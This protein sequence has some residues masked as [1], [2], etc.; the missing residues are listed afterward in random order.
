MTR[1]LSVMK[2]SV[3]ILLGIVLVLGL[4]AFQHFMGVVQEQG[5]SLT[6]RQISIGTNLPDQP[7]KTPSPP[8]SV[9]HSIEHPIVPETIQCLTEGGVTEDDVEITGSLLEGFPCEIDRERKEVSAEVE[10]NCLRLHVEDEIRTVICFDEDAG[11]QIGIVIPP[12]PHLDALDVEIGRNWLGLVLFLLFL[13]T[14]F[15]VWREFEVREKALEEQRL[16]RI[17]REL[18]G[19]RVEVKTIKSAPLFREYVPEEERMLSAEEAENIHST[20]VSEQSMALRA[21]PLKRE[22]IVGAIKEFNRIGKEISIYLREGKLVKARKRYLLLFPLYTRLYHSVD[23]FKQRDLVDVMKYLHDQI[24]IMEKSKKIRHL[25]EEAYRDVDEHRVDQETTDEVKDLHKDVEQA[26][27]L[28]GQ[29]SE[30]RANKPLKKERVMGELDKFQDMVKD[31][32]LPTTQK[33]AMKNLEYELET[34]KKM[35][36]GTTRRRK[37]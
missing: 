9:G 1:L 13:I 30:E 20:L 8:S 18:P 31:T 10:Q 21:T 15:I 12:R 2:D 34:L 11:A 37:H 17:R 3:V 19:E 35:V 32:S 14:L 6:G 29:L 33:K 36:Y 23:T 16:R 22:E 28:L 27:Q 26:D 25:I 5:E 7:N 24:H 4:F